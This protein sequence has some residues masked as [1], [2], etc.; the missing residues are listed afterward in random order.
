MSSVMKLCMLLHI[1]LPLFKSH[2]V[3]IQ[4]MT[5][6]SCNEALNPNKTGTH[7][8]TNPQPPVRHKT[9]TH[10]THTTHY[11]HTHSHTHTH[12]H[13]HSHSLT[14]AHTPAGTPPRLT[15]SLKTRS[16]AGSLEEGTGSPIGTR[17]SVQPP[18]FWAPLLTGGS[19]ERL[20]VLMFK[21]TKLLTRT[22]HTHTP[23]MT[24]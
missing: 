13:T 2:T 12:T 4:I 3:F 16:H 17:K 20:V 18:H 8:P 7:T 1:E 22:M 21:I 5:Y 9:H 24:V 6:V 11:R 15:S 23:Y 14:N 10:Y 19:I